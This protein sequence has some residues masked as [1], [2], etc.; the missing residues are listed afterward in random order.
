MARIHHKRSH[1]EILVSC[2]TMSLQMHKPPFFCF[3]HRELFRSSWMTYFKPSS[4]S[5]QIAPHW[6]SNTSST[7]WRSRLTNGA[8]QTQ[9]PCTSGKP[10]GRKL[11]SVIKVPFGHLSVQV[12]GFKSLSF[13]V[14]AVYLC[15][16]GWTYWRILSLCLTLIRRIT[17]MPVCLSSPRLS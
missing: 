4:A 6:L 9:T 1:L 5:L 11:N 12:Q 13:P 14:Y 16:S 15:V 17:W 8:S 2:E 10:T 7:S 3:H